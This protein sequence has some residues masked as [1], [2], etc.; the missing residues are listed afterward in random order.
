MTTLLTKDAGAATDAQASGGASQA[1][2]PGLGLKARFRR[3]KSM[4][5]MTLPAVVL[6]AV[7][8]YVPIMGN[9][10]AF[11]DYSPYIG[12]ANSPWVGLDNFAR[13]LSDP[14]FWL[15]VKNTLVITAFQLFFFFPV[16]IVLAIL[17][18]SVMRPSLRATIQ[19]IVY[20]P[21]FFSWV[22]VVAVFQQILGGAGLLNQMLLANGWQGLDIMTNPDTFL[23]LIT[24]QSI[25][26]DA[27]WGMIVFLA[28]LNAIDPA[29][30]EAAA[31]DGANR[32]SRMWH[33]T[34]PGLR[35][36]I[37][38]L[39]ILRLGDSLSVGFEQLILQRDA[40][41]AGASEVLD[42]FVYYTGVQN[43]DWSYAAAAGLLKGVVSLVLILGANK[44]AHLFGEA[45]VY[46]KS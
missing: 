17:L 28:A 19:A 13:V 40:V 23:F 4:I 16:P 42:T 6:L 35:P 3:D 12:I 1:T 36:V 29:Q 30:Y 27:G 31:V 45:G 43:G 33:I 24:S 15:A 14:S 25:W 10:V 7:F 32:W 20:L 18:N 41:G 37:I 34:L 44:I 9:I 2:R 5:I 8:A 38:L 22:L 11:Q 26:K 21:H 46:S 39:L